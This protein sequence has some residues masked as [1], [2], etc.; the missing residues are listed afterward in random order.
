M[1]LAN[2]TLILG[3]VFHSQLHWIRCFV[4][5]LRVVMRLPRNAFRSLFLYCWRC[6]VSIVISPLL[7]LAITISI[8]FKKLL[9][10]CFMLRRFWI[11]VWS[12]CNVLLSWWLRD[13]W[14]CLW[15]N[16]LERWWIHF[17]LSWTDRN[18]RI[19]C[20]CSLSWTCFVPSRRLVRLILST[21]SRLSLLMK[22]IRALTLIVLTIPMF[23]F[24]ACLR[25]LWVETSRLW[26]RLAA[27]WLSLYTWIV[28]VSL[29]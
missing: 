8:L 19:R 28:T 3:F 1:S 16:L 14:L 6:L 17:M 15:W 27:I 2:M 29:T 12:Q 10:R 26:V 22:S 18:G 9:L 21:I 24:M 25:C 23:R 7:N 20:S 5:I 13:T 4:L 11:H